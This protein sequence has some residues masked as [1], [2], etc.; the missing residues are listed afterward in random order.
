MN[1]AKESRIKLFTHNDLDGIGNEI[2]AKLAFD[3]VDVTIVRNPAEA[4]LEFD[5]FL[6]HELHKDYDHI[7]I[8][9]ISIS[10]DVAKK[11]D[12]LNLQNLTLLDHHST[13]MY[14][15]K[16]P[17]WAKVEVVRNGIPMSGTHLFYELL[18]AHKLFDGMWGEKA[19]EIF[20]EKIRRYDTWE[21]KDKY[22]DTTASDLNNLFWLYGREKFVNTYVNRF[23]S[24]QQFSTHRDVWVEMFSDTDKLVLD[25]N[26][27]EKKA[28]FIRK[29]K[30]MIVSTYNGYKV[31]I[32]YADRFIS[33]LGNH[34]SE[35]Y[36]NLDYVALIDIGK[37][38]VSLRTIHDDIHLGEE[39]A[40]KFG[41][42][43]HSKASGFS[44][45][46][47]LKELSYFLIMNQD[48]TS[49]KDKLLCLV[50]G[51]GLIGMSSK[52]SDTWNK[53]IDKFRK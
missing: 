6:F 9:D 1:L 7:F 8:T 44:F 23:N 41:G 42:G 46:P 12:S 43:G 32:V 24:L 20:V 40:K 35:M 19:L 2:L 10:E 48:K 5:E 47:D 30:E 52:L 28:Y 29:E 21:W 34:L 31:G 51:D 17:L 39:I 26:R 15:N 37:C 22:F 49:L 16:H 33:E 27:E 38:K 36:S 13:A 45:H 50:H 3:Y 14:L 4:S 25:M 11:V 18:N 53:L